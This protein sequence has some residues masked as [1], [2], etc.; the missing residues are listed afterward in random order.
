[1]GS[2]CFEDRD[3]FRD[4]RRGAGGSR[5]FRL[6]L[7]PFVLLQAICAAGGHHTGQRKT[8]E[9]LCQLRSFHERT[10]VLVES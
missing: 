6:L 5:P 4:R 2:G 7:Q 8:V 9:R 10:M 3:T 1:M